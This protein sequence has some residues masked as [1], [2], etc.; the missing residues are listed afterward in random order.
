MI[1][2]NNALRIFYCI[3]VGGDTLQSYQPRAREREPVVQAV[4]LPCAWLAVRR[5]MEHQPVDKARAENV[6]L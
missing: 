1:I 6:S 3:S 5:A 4:C 2:S